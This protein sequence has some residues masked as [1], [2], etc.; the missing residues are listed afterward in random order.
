[1]LVKYIMK[2][3]KDFFKGTKLNANEIAIEKNGKYQSLVQ[4]LENI[5]TKLEETK[6]VV[7]WTNPNPKVGFSKSTV[8]LDVSVEDYSYY[9]II[10]KGYCSNVNVLSTGKIP[11]NFA[12]TML[13]YESSSTLYLR[14]TMTPS[15][16]N[17]TF[18]DCSNNNYITPQSIIFYK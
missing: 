4:Y 5:N 15:G 2:L 12:A 7:G 10:Y 9:E 14:G 11:V 17:I 13:Y 18:A 8:E 3:F 16:K 1:M 6:P